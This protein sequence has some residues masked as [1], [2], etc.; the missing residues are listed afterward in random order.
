[1]T[2]KPAQKKLARPERKK[3]SAAEAAMAALLDRFDVSYRQEVP[4]VQGLGK[5]DFYLPDHRIAIEVDGCR[6]HGCP[7]CKKGEDGF[8]RRRHDGAKTRRLEGAGYE[9][10]RF[11]ECKLGDPRVERIVERLAQGEP[12]EA[13]DLYD[14]L[15]AE[16][17]NLDFFQA[18]RELSA[19]FCAEMVVAAGCACDVKETVERAVELA[20]A[21]IDAFDDAEDEWL[22]TAEIAPGWE[23]VHGIAA[24]NRYW[25]AALKVAVKHRVPPLK[26]GQGDFR[27]E[28]KRAAQRALEHEGGREGAPGDSGDDPEG[29]RPPVQ[30]EFRRA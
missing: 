2:P 11:W 16:E 3:P 7:Q 27:D 24:W 17:D 25:D 8:E 12:D 13:L 28:F 29:P 5:V 10:L 26:Q 14:D 23:D 15:A 18:L 30:F 22:E 21:A 20:Q 1:M 9:V 4:L 6:W 19:D